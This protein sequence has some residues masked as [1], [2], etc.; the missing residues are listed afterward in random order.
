MLPPA[1]LA[2]T[3]TQ[4]GPLQPPQG[5]TIMELQQQLVTL[6][7]QL[8]HVEGQLGSMGQSA[9]GREARIAE[10]EGKLQDMQQGQGHAYAQPQ[11]ALAL[12][13]SRAMQRHV[14]HDWRPRRR[15]SVLRPRCPGA[16]HERRTHGDL[17]WAGA[18]HDGAH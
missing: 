10:L 16:R 9:V 5:Q 12:G 7:Q 8:S 18:C 15:P 1:H 3:P 6:R 14:D 17:H 2:T 11:P 13:D 4:F